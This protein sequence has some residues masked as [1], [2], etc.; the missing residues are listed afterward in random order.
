MIDGLTPE[1]YRAARR[2]ANLELLILLA[3]ALAVAGA[4]A[5]TILVASYSPRAAVAIGQTIGQLSRARPRHRPPGRLMPA[6]RR[7]ARNLAPVRFPTLTRL[8][9]DDMTL[10]EGVRFS[11]G[12]AAILDHAAAHG[13]DIKP[14][15]RIRGGAV[16]VT[17]YPPDKEQG[18]SSSPR[19][20]AARTTPRTTTTSGASSNAPGCHPCPPARSR[21]RR[22]P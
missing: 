13:F 11:D 19:R 12:L 8:T 16:G 3:R 18:R 2:G 10:I 7:A 9:G 4:V 5:A 20:T 22:H 21:R 6:P 17:V 14:V 1:Q 15:A